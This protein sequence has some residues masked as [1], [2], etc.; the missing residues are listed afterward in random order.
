MASLRKRGRVW[1]YRYTDADGI[2]RERKGFTD[3][4]E[5]ERVAAQAE[6]GAAKVRD[7]IIDP[8]DA[9][10]RD[11]GARPL[12]DHIDDF[13]RYLTAKGNTPK[14]ADLTV[15]RIARTVALIRAALAEIDPPR[16]VPGEFREAA[17]ALIARTAATAR[18]ADLTPSRV[19]Q[20]LGTLREG[21]QVARDL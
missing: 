20:A 3:R 19:A 8:R 18:I 12:S 21:G 7:G 15:K 11:H 13:D 1:Y 2:R 16:R 4:R 14:H 10:Y 6:A 5:T 17:D 9:A